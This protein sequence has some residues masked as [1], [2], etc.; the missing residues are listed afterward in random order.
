VDSTTP[1]IVGAAQL[2]QRVDDLAEAREAAELMT[3]VVRAAAADSGAHDIAKRAGLVVTIKGAWSYRDPARIVADA[4]G[5]TTARTALTADGGNTPQLVVD[6]IA[7]RI[8]RGELDVAVI[9]GAETIWSRRRMRSAGVQRD[10]TAQPEDVTP[11]EQLGRDLVLGDDFEHSRGLTLPVDI[12]PLFES[13]IRHRRGETLDAHRDRLA[14]MWADFNAVAVDNPFAWFR[15]PMTADDIRDPSPSNRMVAFPYTKAM[16]SNWDVDQAAAVIMCSAEAASAAAVPRDRWVFPYGGAEADDTALVSHR[17]ELGR[18]PAIAAAWRALTTQCG[19]GI[20]DIAHLD[21]YSCFPSAVQAAIE[22]IG[23]DDSRR[24]TVTGGLTFAGGPLNNYVS[25]SIAAMV[26][27]LR[28]DLS[29]RGL[30][31]ANGGFI[32]K[33]ALGIYSATP[34]PAPFARAALGEADVEHNP[35]EVA[36]DATGK[37]DIEAYTVM[38]D[39][40]GPTRALVGFR[41][42][43]GRRT[44]GFSQESDVMQSLV[45]SDHVGA[46][47]TLDGDGHVHL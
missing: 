7:E 31:T 44:W 4:V 43:D 12:Y 33:H 29:A 25:H 37:L 46:P 18:S 5:A 19:L 10:V 14:K 1:V 22:A 42:E 47:A 45:A 41:T 24:L 6:V 15:T 9:V 13:A 11:D 30:V 28:E 21:V 27:V 17:D 8:S 32:T 16:C 26:G 40:S 3:D 39:H 2:I 35:R 38:H 23:I 36:A 20:D 34:P